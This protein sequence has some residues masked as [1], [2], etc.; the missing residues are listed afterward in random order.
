[1]PSLRRNATVPV[2]APVPTNA[3]WIER[4]ARRFARLRGNERRTRELHGRVATCYPMSDCHS[5]KAVGASRTT[6]SCVS[7]PSREDRRRIP[8]GRARARAGSPAAS[9]M[10]IRTACDARR[11]QPARAPRL[12]ADRGG[13]SGSAGR[14]A[15]RRRSGRRRLEEE[16]DRVGR[17]RIER[18]RT[19]HVRLDNPPPGDKL[20]ETCWSF[21]R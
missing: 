7:S 17:G 19:I 8:V 20:A 13:E 1:M 9:S 5:T 18:R 21:P 10:E 15:F 11:V 6:P 2:H 14:I 12:P 16:I 3:R 4:T